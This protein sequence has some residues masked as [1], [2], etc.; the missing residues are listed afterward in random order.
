M[1]RRRFRFFRLFPSKAAE[2]EEEE[3]TSLESKKEQKKRKC[4]KGGLF[5]FFLPKG[6]YIGRIKQRRWF[7]IYLSSIRPPLLRRLFL[8]KEKGAF[9][10]G[11]DG[12]FFRRAGGE[13]TADWQERKSYLFRLPPFQRPIFCSSSY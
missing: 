12:L 6:V 7:E 5:L 4:G 9:E 11:L 3:A 8:S 10:K 13:L 1:K 2:E